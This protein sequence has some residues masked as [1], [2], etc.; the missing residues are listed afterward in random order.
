MWGAIRSM[1]RNTL[2]TSRTCWKVH[3][4]F[5]ENTLGI[6]STT[7]LPSP[8][9]KKSSPHWPQELCVLWHFWVP[10]IV[11]YVICIDQMSCLL[12]FLFFC[13][14]PIWSTHHSQTKETME[15]PQNRRS[16]FEV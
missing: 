5:H 15:A 9:R 7:H 14:E 16:Y 12:S 8:Q 3:E 13:N 2:G 1:L 4:N 10:V 11:S 6:Q